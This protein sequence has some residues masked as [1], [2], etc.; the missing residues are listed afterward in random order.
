MIVTAFIQGDL[1]HL[2]NAQAKAVDQ[3]ARKAMKIVAGGIRR[4]I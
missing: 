3:G 4:N 1:G 2:L